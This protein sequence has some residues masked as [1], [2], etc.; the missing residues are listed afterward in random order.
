MSGDMADHLD[1]V[2]PFQSVATDNC[3]CESALVKQGGTTEF[4]PDSDSSRIEA[5]IF[6]NA[7]YRFQ[8]PTCPSEAERSL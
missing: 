8:L 4:Y 3:C 2:T 5:R 7:T 6:R 1:T